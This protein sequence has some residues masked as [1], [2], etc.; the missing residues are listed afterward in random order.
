M[1]PAIFGHGLTCI[2][3][4]VPEPIAVAADLT[5]EFARPPSARASAVT[6][7]PVAMDVQHRR[8]EVRPN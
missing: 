2:G 3:P 7:D 6:P 4:N 8:T 5:E 1:L